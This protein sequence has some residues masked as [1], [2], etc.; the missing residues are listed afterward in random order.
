MPATG[1]ASLNPVLQAL[2][3][4]GFTWFLTALGS[5][6]VFAFKSINRRVLDGMLGLPLE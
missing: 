6:S 2:L 5:A 4:T 3:A 1:L